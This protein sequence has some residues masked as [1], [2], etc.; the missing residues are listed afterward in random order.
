MA[1]TMFTV[2][3]LLMCCST[4]I[5]NLPTANAK[6]T[7]DFDW[8]DLAFVPTLVAH[9]QPGKNYTW[10]DNV[11]RV[12]ARITLNE[13]NKSG[14]LTLDAERLHVGIMQEYILT[15]LYH[16]STYSIS[17][18][19]VHTTTLSLRD[20]DIEDIKLRGLRVFWSE[21]GATKSIK[22]LISFIKM[23]YGFYKNPEPQT[24]IENSLHFIKHH[25]NYEMKPRNATRKITIT[26][27]M[28]NIGDPIY[29]ARLDGTDPLIM[30][31]T[32]SHFG[33]CVIVWEFNG[34]KYVCEA[35]TASA[36]WPI[37]NVQCNPFDEWMNLAYE[38]GYNAIFVPLDPKLRAKINKTRGDSFIK[39]M[40]GHPY[41]YQVFAFG[42][43]DSPEN[44]FPKPFTP[45]IYELLV[46]LGNKY[47]HDFITLTA[48]NPLEKR[49]NVW[50]D[51]AVLYIL[52]AERQGKTL[53][54]VS[55]I[56]E[57]DE[58]LYDNMSLHVCSTF[59][60]AVLK[61]AGVFD[62]YTFNANEL[63]PFDLTQLKIYDESFVP[64]SECVEDDPDLKDKHY[65]QIVGQYT[66][67]LEEDYN[68]F[69]MHDH[70]SE[71]CPY[72]VRGDLK[73]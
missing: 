13:A 8:A 73:C 50:Y 5:I 40:L 65:C 72:R 44:N 15:S 54:E 46:I 14:L 24:A 20:A 39:S 3:T 30:Y 66:A 55:L 21:A 23:M 34:E 25:L 27:D 31:F 12:T 71:T 16:V 53:Y 17:K 9:I 56:P 6:V 38:A 57:S 36:Y 7:N 62:G 1:K 35:Q 48:S 19:G 59:V 64:P 29:I 18:K 33:H 4:I 32:G 69:P 41:G 10:E 45:D 26:K 68:T 2:V 58:W 47:M 51:D 28:V 42:D 11:Y 37:D 67:R 60:A 52:E 63:S 61:N 43:I 49:M 70:L 22:S